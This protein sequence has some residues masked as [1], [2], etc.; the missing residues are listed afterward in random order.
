MGR[1][2]WCSSC[3]TRLICI[4]YHSARCSPT[5]QVF[6]INSSFFV[7]LCRVQLLVILMWS[8]PGRLLGPS[9][10]NKLLNSQSD[11]L[12]ALSTKGVRSPKS[13]DCETSTQS[14][15][16][17]LSKGWVCD[18]YLYFFENVEL[19][20]KLRLEIVLIHW[21]KRMAGPVWN[22]DLQVISGELYLFPETPLD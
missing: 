11:P 20:T 3:T 10:V 21:P 19:H 4:S 12:S 8:S 7:I 22:P 15:A 13:P 18:A 16:S 17:D 2:C 9:L 14:S 1:L 5:L 6:S